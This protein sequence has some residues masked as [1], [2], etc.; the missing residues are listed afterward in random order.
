M[1]R[2]V[3][4][5]A[6]ATSV[7]AAA[8]FVLI[9][10]AFGDRGQDVAILRLL[11][12]L[13][14]PAAAE[15]AVTATDVLERRSMEGIRDRVSIALE[16]ESREEFCDEAEFEIDVSQEGVVTLGGR[17][18]EASSRTR[19]GEIAQYQVGVTDVDL[20]LSVQSGARDPGA[21][22]ANPVRAELR[23]KGLAE[24]D[25]T[26]SDERLSEA[27][28]ASL[29]AYLGSAAEARYACFSD[30]RVVGEGWSVALDVDDE[31]LRISGAAVDAERRARVRSWA[32]WVLQN[33]ERLQVLDLDFAAEAEGGFWAALG[34]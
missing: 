34:F 16:L 5:A 21:A 17:V 12:A 30:P 1:S 6:R 31:T 28:A 14:S 19:A 20:R 33:S 3:A 13:I 24:I 4:P 18:C 27:L 10:I 9:A 8:L 26:D 22:A 29:A 7:F 23:S 25:R 15:S 2:A 11:P 32:R